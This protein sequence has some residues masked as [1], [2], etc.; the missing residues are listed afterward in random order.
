VG[1][2]IPPKVFLPSSLEPPVEIKLLKK[3]LY[4]IGGG[5]KGLF[6][7]ERA[8]AHPVERRLLK[9]DLARAQRLGQTHDGKEIYLAHGQEAS[10]LVLEIARLRE[11]TFRKVGEGTGARL[12]TDPFDNWYHHLLLWDA[13]EREVVGAYRLG[14]GADIM[15]SRGIEGF[16]SSTLFQFAPALQQLLPRSIDLGRSFIQE[17]YWSS[18]ALDCLWQGIGAFLAHNPRIQYLLGPVSISGSY[19]APACELLVFFFRQWFG[20]HDD[21]AVS[22][23]PYRIPPSRI[24]ELKRSFPGDNYRKEYQSLKNALKPYNCTVPILYKHYSDL[25]EAGGVRFLDFGVDS[26]FQNCIDGLI[27][28]DLMLLSPG[29][30]ARYIPAVPMNESLSV[31]AG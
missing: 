26:Q 2:P 30:R 22:H 27:L 21:F 9:L 13:T 7:T 5:K 15:A 17:K 14:L 18:R 24:E 28:V 8:V 31:C 19:P 29:K 12:D 16:Y 4:R 6:R 23:L 10:H 20:G 11:L 3:H 25:S 1:D